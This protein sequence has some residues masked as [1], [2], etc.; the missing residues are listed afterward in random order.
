MDVQEFSFTRQFANCRWMP[1]R[2]ALAEFKSQVFEK[3]VNA[4]AGSCG[5]VAVKEKEFNECGFRAGN[6]YFL[7]TDGSREK[8]D[9]GEVEVEIGDI[10]EAHPQF[11]QT[12]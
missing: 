6:E 5:L 3:I 11:S 12:D 2:Q 8:V 9:L 4:R 10:V 7:R 1:F